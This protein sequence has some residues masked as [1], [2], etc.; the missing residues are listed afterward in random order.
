MREKNGRHYRDDISKGILLSETS[1][2]H[3]DIIGLGNT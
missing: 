1:L 3:W 2:I